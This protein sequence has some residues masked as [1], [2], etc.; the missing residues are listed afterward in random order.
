MRIVVYFET[1]SYAEVIAIFK[2]ELA[3]TRALPSLEKLA[4]ELGFARVTESVEEI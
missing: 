3:Y 4:V 2:S 1:D